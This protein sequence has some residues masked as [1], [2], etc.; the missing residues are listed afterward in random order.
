M[1]PMASGLARHRM[2]DS[3]CATPG[4]CGLT[5]RCIGTRAGGRK[6]DEDDKAALLAAVFDHYDLAYPR[7]YGDRSCKCPVHEDTHASASVN[8]ETG[9]WTCFACGSGGDGF[10]IIEMKEGVGFADAHRIAEG[11][12]G[13][14]DSGVRRE[15][16][17][18]FGS[19]VSSKPRNRPRKG[20][21]YVPPWS[22]L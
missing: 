7:G 19:R 22:R 13:G 1:R 5:I 16:S 21:G 4:A 2:T 6:L 3:G 14:S 15:S 11:I 10:T 20:E 17:E 9:L 18:L 8:T 12:L